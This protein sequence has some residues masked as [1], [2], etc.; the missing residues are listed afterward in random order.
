MIK[1]N[2]KRILA[3]IPAGVEVVGAAK[4]RTVEEIMESVEA[5]L[6][7]IGENY[8]FLYRYFRLNCSR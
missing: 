4:T 3:E 6:K 2:V 7:I 5:G 8:P 1:E